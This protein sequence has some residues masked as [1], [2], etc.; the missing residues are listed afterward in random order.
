MLRPRKFTI[1]TIIISTS[2]HWDTFSEAIYQILQSL[3]L[4]RN[5]FLVREAMY[6]SSIALTRKAWKVL[7]SSNSVWD[8]IFKWCLIFALWLVSE[9]ASDW[10]IESAANWNLESMKTVYLMLSKSWWIKG[11]IW[12]GKS[13][14]IFCKSNIITSSKVKSKS[15][16]WQRSPMIISWLLRDLLTVQVTVKWCWWLYNGDRLIMLVTE[17]LCWR[18]FHNCDF[19]IYRIVDSESVINICHQHMSSPTSVTKIDIAPRGHSSLLLV[20]WSLTHFWVNIIH[21]LK[22]S[23][24]FVLKKFLRIKNCC[25]FRSFL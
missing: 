8:A 22:N 5:N 10:L 18:F 9:C 15:E 13:S 12:I 23:F 21:S 6:L 11:W 2:Q 17:H 7:Y 20:R 14:W 19:S 4:V 3:C 24:C 16:L 1:I 25:K